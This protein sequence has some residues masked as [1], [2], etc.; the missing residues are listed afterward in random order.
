MRE[1]RKF[2]YFPILLGAG[3]CAMAALGGL[4]LGGERLFIDADAAEPQIGRM[5]TEQ[6]DA[7]GN[8]VTVPVEYDG[9]KYILKDML[10]N[11]F[12]YD[13]SAFV[14]DP[15]SR[16]TL[17]QQIENTDFPIYTSENGIFEDGMAIS[18]YYNTIRA[19]DF[20]TVEN[21]GM[22]F[23]GVNGQNDEIQ[24]NLNENRNEM[25]FYIYAH[26]NS[27][28]MRFNAGYTTFPNQNAS[29]MIVGDGSLDNPNFDLYRQGAAC[30]VIAH[31]YMHGIT[32]SVARLSTAG[33]DPGAIN[34]AVSDIFGALIE[35]HDLTEDDFW[36]M[37]EDCS[38]RGSAMRSVK[39]PKHGGTPGAETMSDKKIC[40]H[41]WHNQNCDNGGVHFNSTII[42]HLQYSAYTYAPE[43]FT[44]ERIG[45]LWFRTVQTLTPNAT[46]QEFAQKFRAAAVA[47]Q[48]EQKAIDAIDYSL[49]V[50]GLQNTG[51][52]HK[53]SFMDDKG[54][55]ISD[56]I[57]KHGEA[58]VAP[59]APE[60]EPTEGYR[61]I[62]EGWDKDFDDVTGDLVVRAVYREE[63]R[64][65]LVEF[66]DA[67]G[68]VFKKQ[69]NVS[70]PDL[71][72]VKSTENITPPVKESTAQYVYEFDHWETYLSESDGK[73]TITPVYTQ[74][75][76]QYKVVYSYQGRE[77]YSTVRD[78]GILELIDVPEGCLGW[79]VDENCTIAASGR[80]LDRDLTIYGKAEHDFTGLIIAIFCV[81]VTVLAGGAIVAV[82]VYKKKHKRKF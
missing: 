54:K 72:A 16:T 14:Y 79:Y 10:R 58:A 35:G 48:F 41:R 61:Y 33:G 9:E 53:V 66:M 23:P 36:L 43:C 28:G 68:N 62:F 69:E 30:D 39:D 2:R 60:K 73:V 17:E 13:A 49:Y 45:K 67:Q 29:A 77:Y 27:G 76:R 5:E 1:K 70:Y 19:Y 80:M 31:E 21:V 75:V 6:T 63:A 26:L 59:E 71:S 44:P 52:F 57:V 38:A 3:A 74:K 15:S 24:G 25:P 42:S 82:V 78:Y 18:I 47:L 32:N 11:I 8:T 64:V 51:A 46:F 37:G 55:L 12:V 50:S 4:L 65:Y 81:G 7:L 40:Q 56:M 20:Y 34:E 22:D